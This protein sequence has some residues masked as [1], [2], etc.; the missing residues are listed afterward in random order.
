M[1]AFE[2]PVGPAQTFTGTEGALRYVDMLVE[3]DWNVGGICCRFFELFFSDDVWTL[4][5]DNTNL[6]A[7]KEL[8]VVTEEEHCRTFH[9]VTVEEMKAFFGVLIFMGINHLP[10]LEQYWSTKNFYIQSNLSRVFPLIR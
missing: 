7:A 9:D 10:R 8:D 6:Y 3:C 5:V 2:A 1:T 4:L